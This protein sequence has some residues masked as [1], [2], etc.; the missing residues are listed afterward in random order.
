M[1]ID[2]NCLSCSGVPS[3]TM[4][5]FKMACVSYQ[6]SEVSY[7]NGYFKRG[8]LMKM[9]KTLIDK[10]EEIIN[11]QSK[12]HADQN[13][14]TGKVFKDLVQYY[15]NI[16]KSIFSSASIKNDFGSS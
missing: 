3:H 2:G 8:K 14:K 7:R 15:N 13:I 6:P 9:R 1:A 4:Q 5:L 16:E 10:C 11:N 12:S